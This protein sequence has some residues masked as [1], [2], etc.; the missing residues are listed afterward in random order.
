LR[1]SLFA[2]AAVAVFTLAMQA[3]AANDP[4]TGSQT[5]TFARSFAK[6]FPKIAVNAM[7]LNKIAKFDGNGASTDSSMSEVGGDVFLTAAAAPYGRLY[8]WPDASGPFINFDGSSLVV[9]G[10]GAISLTNANTVVTGVNSLSTSAALHVRNSGLSSLLY[11]ES[12]GKVGVGTTAPAATLHV[13]TD[14]NASAGLRISNPNA[15][16]GA[17]ASLRFGINGNDSSGAVFQN[18]TANASYGG[19]GS[20]N[21]GTT[22][23]YPFSIITNN[24]SRLFVFADGMVGI[25]P[26]PAPPQ[27]RLDIVGTANADASRRV[28][29]IL[30]DTAMTAG[31]GAGLDLGGKYDST[32]GH[33]TAFATVQGVKANATVADRSGKLVLAVENSAGVTVPMATLDGNGLNVS[34]TISGTTVIGA[35]YQDVAEWVPATEKMAPGTVVV[36]N[37]E[38]RNEVMPSARAYD[39]AVAGVVSAQPGV[40]LGVAGD[41]KAQIATTGRVKVRVDATAGAVEIGDLLVTSNKSGTAMK[42]RPVDLGGVPIHR[43]G[44]V[45]GKALEPLPDGEG[46]ILVLLSLQ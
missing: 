14:V 16:A 11:V 29:R 38:H 1:R 10:K 44:T 18:S 27:N 34:G 5:T 36:L 3:V 19:A 40:I 32:F 25:G 20:V 30:D 43:P 22:A 8:L 17:D 4:A 15:G 45:I 28:V 23:A 33:Y 37:R 41:S 12:D 21:I 2:V 39:T 46:E 9:N 42:S 13:K 35:V 6:A 26:I 31:V 7:T 24:A